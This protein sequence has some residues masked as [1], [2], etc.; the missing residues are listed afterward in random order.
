MQRIYFKNMKIIKTY[1]SFNPF[2][3]L[4]L[5]RFGYIID[6]YLLTKNSDGTYDYNGYLDFSNMKLKSL[7]EIPIRFNRVFDYYCNNNF[8]ISLEGAPNFCLG[9]FYC[10]S[11]TLIS[12][13]HSPLNVC[14]N[15]NCESN[16]LLTSKCLSQISGRFTKWFNPFKI[17]DHVI[18]TVKQMTYEQQMAE[19]DFLKYKKNTKSPLRA[20]VFM[21]EILDGLDVNYGEGTRKMVEYSKSFDIGHLI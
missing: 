4:D 16:N 13:L 12:L 21:K 9:D 18:E 17:T 2:K 3:N 7:T 1:E 15:F 19:L 5:G 14:G 20:F 8:L 6:K 10:N 11:N